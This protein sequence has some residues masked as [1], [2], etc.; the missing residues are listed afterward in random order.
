MLQELFDKLSFEDRVSLYRIKLRD[1]QEDLDLE[2]WD[3]YCRLVKECPLS[4]EQIV[5]I[6]GKKDSTE[7]VEAIRGMLD[8]VWG[9]CKDQYLVKTIYRLSSQYG[10]H[11]YYRCVN[12][13]PQK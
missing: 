6:A 3:E 1:R 4:A 12:Y 2:A 7:E 8:C 10:A 11:L 13:L 9:Y 5:S